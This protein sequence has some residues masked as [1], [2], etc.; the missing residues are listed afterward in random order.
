MN[1]TSELAGVPK[2]SAPIY[3]ATKA[4]M[5]SFTKALRYQLEHTASKV[6]EIVPVLVETEMI[7]GRGKGKITP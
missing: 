1:I 3:C 2:Q 6:F 5:H 4:A 7:K